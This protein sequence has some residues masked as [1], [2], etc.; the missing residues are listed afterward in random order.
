MV[1]I[2]LFL[3][4]IVGNEN[5]VMI[6]ENIIINERIVINKIERMKNCPRCKSLLTKTH[7]DKIV[8]RI[9]GFV[10][11]PIIITQRNL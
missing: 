10:T 6:V 8:C 11:V 1:M 4:V 7:H 9:C 3:V 5:M 2:V